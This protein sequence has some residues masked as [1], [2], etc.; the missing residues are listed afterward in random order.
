MSLT[1]SS[2]ELIQTLVN[3]INHSAACLAS[4]GTFASDISRRTL[5]ATAEKLVLA[6]RSPEEN[7]FAIAQ[8][9]N[10]NSIIPVT[11]KITEIGTRLTYHACF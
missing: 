7:I 10:P 9:V 2:P 1:L 3:E 4:N 11:I 6:T 5:I 8:Q